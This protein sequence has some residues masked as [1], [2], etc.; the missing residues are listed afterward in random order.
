MLGPGERGEGGGWA[1]RSAWWSCVR[2][3]PRPHSG[4]PSLG[5]T[6]RDSSQSQLSE[7]VFTYHRHATVGQAR[8]FQSKIYVSISS[9]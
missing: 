3:P 8:H 5:T 7:T 9:T 2:R 1:G 6:L 4:A